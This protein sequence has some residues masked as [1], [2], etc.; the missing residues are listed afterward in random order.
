[1]PAWL[2]SLTASEK[3]GLMLQAVSLAMRG[4]GWTAPNP[5]VGALLVRDGHIVAR[6]W[7][8]RFGGAHAE[9]EA[10]RQA[11]SQGVDPSECALWVTLEPCNHS[12]KTPPCTQAIVQSGIRNVFIGAADPNTAVP[13]GGAEFLQSQGVA[14][15]MDIASQA[16][17]DLIADFMVW[18]SKRRPFVQ[19]KLASTLDGRI[20]NR[21]GGPLAISGTQS[22]QAVQQLRRA[23][24]AVLVGGN[25]FYQD[26][27][28]LTC[29]LSHGASQ[30]Q[31]LAVVI[32]S[33]LPAP[34]AELNLLR[35]SP[36]ELI[37]WTDDR[38]ATSHEADSLAEQG[39]R[40]WSLG[41]KPG[42]LDLEAGLQ[43]LYDE[44]GCHY[45]L[46]EG[47]GR[48]AS[49]L[50][51]AGVV[52]ELHLFLAPKVLGDEKAVSA[53]SGRSVFGLN[54]AL[55]WRLIES[56]PIGSDL[57]LIYRPFSGA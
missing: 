45:V 35:R 44:A 53:F 10:I 41:P 15:E 7:H 43:R 13:G 33:R 18:Q 51:E 38:A 6:G 39:V 9:V 57:W 2:Q 12:G 48:L 28:R 42:A 26:N 20:G 8:K 50:A 55:E 54:E 5:C 25:T 24:G 3:E 32:T 30:T 36:Q 46:C 4:K 1:M 16:C 40:V 56:R 23:A 37:F 22:R 29:R 19:L 52:D 47:G 34:A 49:R 21:D 31:P 11:E 17:R 14:V 27:P